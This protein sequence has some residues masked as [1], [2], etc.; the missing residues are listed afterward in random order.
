[1]VERVGREIL[2]VGNKKAARKNKEVEENCL[3]CLPENGN[4][5]AR[6][7]AASIY[8]CA[9]FLLLLLCNFFLLFLVFFRFTLL[10]GR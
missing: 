5:N 9:P 7:T 2:G 4:V 10:L 3:S 8:F 6:C 1:M